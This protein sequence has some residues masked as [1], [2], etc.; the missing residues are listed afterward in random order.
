MSPLRWHG[1]ARTGAV[2]YIPSFLSLIFS[3]TQPGNSATSVSFIYIYINTYI[4][5]FV[6]AAVVSCAWESQLW[7]SGAS[8]MADLC[9]ESFNELLIWTNCSLNPCYEDR[10]HEARIHFMWKLFVLIKWELGFGGQRNGLFKS[11]PVKDRMKF[12]VP[13]EWEVVNGLC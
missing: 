10:E 3:Y 11:N 5:Q 8:C 7:A 4:L 6:L 13:S 2:L 12:W 1:K 9:M